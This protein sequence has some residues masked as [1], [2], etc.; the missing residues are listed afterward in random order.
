MH[1]VY[2]IKDLSDPLWRPV[3]CFAAAG[4]TRAAHRLS[5]A[6]SVGRCKE[7]LGGCKQPLGSRSSQAFPGV[8]AGPHHPAPGT[9]SE[10]SGAPTQTAPVA[11][12]PPW[13]VAASPRAW[14]AGIILAGA[15]WI[16]HLP[17]GPRNRVSPGCEAMGRSR[18]AL[19]IAAQGARHHGWEGGKH[20]A[21]FRGKGLQLTLKMKDAS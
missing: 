12:L 5:R 10:H 16:T 20:R 14:S 3:F 2:F 17:G 6:G 4:H 15:L 7:P 18:Q 8:A 1:T 19:G 21:A 11:S 13:W 9:V